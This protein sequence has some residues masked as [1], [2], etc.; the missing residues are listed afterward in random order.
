MVAMP[1]DQSSARTLAA[2]I[3]TEIANDRAFSALCSNSSET[4]D[5]GIVI[6]PDWQL[7][8]AHLP[9]VLTFVASVVLA[10]AG[11]WASP[12]LFRPRVACDRGRKCRAEVRRPA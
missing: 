10:A 2:R 12:A 6:G 11:V 4:F 8:P 1:G 7:A 3:D 5:S 9:T